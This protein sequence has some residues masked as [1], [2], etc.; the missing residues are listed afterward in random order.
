MASGASEGKSPPIQDPAKTGRV[1]HHLVN[2]VMTY[3]LGWDS[4]MKQ[5]GLKGGTWL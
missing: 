1:N 3:L 5:S 2:Q 4:I